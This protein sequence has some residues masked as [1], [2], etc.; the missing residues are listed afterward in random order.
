MPHFWP[1]VP[2]V[3]FSVASERTPQRSA[4]FVDFPL[5]PHVTFATMIGQ[6]ISHY[7]IL[8]KLGGGGMGVVY[9]AEDTRLHR[10][11]A[12]K[13]LPDE[14]AQN[15]QAL[16]RF[17]REAQAASALNHPNI[18]TIYD[19][20]EQ[21]GQAF[22]AMEYLDGVTL[23]N[24]VTGRALEMEQLLDLAIEITDAL[25]AAHA[26]GIVHRDI[27]PA[28][29]F[30]TKRG[31]AKILDFGLA[32]VHT[33]ASAADQGNINTE[34]TVAE[35]NLTSPGTAVGTVAYMSPEQARGKDLDGRTD[36]FSFGTVLYEMATGTLPFRGE[37]SAVIFQSILD[38][39]PTPPIR[40]NPN[41]PAKLEEI[42]NKALEK[43]RD[44][45]YQSAAE[46]R[47]DLKRLRR[48]TSSG[49]V[50]VESDAALA[51]ASSGSHP[52]SAAISA[53]SAPVAT[54]P[55]K[56]SFPKAVIAAV[57]V[58]LLAAASFAGY[59]MFGHH[60]ALNTQ[61]ME[62]TKLTESGHAMMAAISPDGRYVVYVKND[63]G[64]ESLWMRHVATK[65]DV[66]VLPPDTEAFVGL[67][68]SPDGNYIYFTRSDKSNALYHFLFS[69]PVLGGSP[70]QLIR[71]I[72]SAV[73]FSPDGKQFVF[74]RGVPDVNAVEVHIA[75]ADG[76]G[77]HVLAQIP[78][79]LENFGIS[80]SPDGKNIAVAIL[81]TTKDVK[82]LIDIVSVADGSVR[83]LYSAT[84]F[85]GR[86]FWLPDGDSLLI[87][88]GVPQQNRNQIWQVLYPSGEHQRF[89]NDLSNYRDIT[90]TRDASAL[91]A[92]DTKQ[93]SHIWVAPQG[94]INLAT[95]ISSEGTLDTGVSA[96]PNGKLL[97]HSQESDL[98][99]MNSD[100]SQRTVLIPQMQNYISRSSCGDRYL[101][102]DSFESGRL[103]L[104]RTD[105]DGGNP[106]K[107]A[108]DI[109]VSQ[110]SPDGTWL[111]YAADT[112]SGTKIYRMGIDGGTPTEVASAR[113]GGMLS[114]SPDGKFL[115]YA[116]Q[117]GS[118]TP[119]LKMGII[120]GTGGSPVQVLPL[121]SGAGIMRWSPD[122]KAVQ[123]ILTRKGAGNIWEQP[124]TGGDPHQVTNFASGLIFGWC[125]SRDGKNMFL[126]KGDFTSDVVLI[127]NFR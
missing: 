51:A 14:V 48:D 74:L 13:F 75:N 71:D 66:Q 28:N 76:S 12:L 44:L 29:I 93:I 115:A 72:D 118:P 26:G 45:R 77:D 81:Q 25:D 60:H 6:S 120:A 35:E 125:W 114:I 67:A 39:A 99:S 119:Q 1:K 21:N 37:T 86:P 31:H 33:S 5:D 63:A 27:K 117:E 94:K 68:F 23:K 101:L 85:V 103:H 10:F 95:Q 55:A 69:M 102:F 122:G 11:V 100:G 24:M 109:S 123:Y 83:T 20:G 53:V 84:D 22:I 104:L 80:L 106:V 3:G 64:Q 32:K 56:K 88:M 70:R 78:A 38:R 127:S 54:A 50:R 98:V 62:I 16:A 58:L 111:A 89:T 97:V 92:V 41:V 43:D 2:E 57:A 79:N 4:Q 19:I 124:L 96:G 36:L 61:N 9:K 112:T 90:L 47:A 116:F 52:V 46:M 113:G 40:L 91:A 126:A 110:C 105:V 73:S 59:R 87:P 7:T 15:P 30:V 107:L 65:S 18:C 42:I 121:P 34:A 82:W 17:Q 108:D 8:E 49:H